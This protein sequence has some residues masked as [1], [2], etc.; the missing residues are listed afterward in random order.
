[1][2]KSPLNWILVTQV[3]MYIVNLWKLV[4]VV[5]PGHATMCEQASGPCMHA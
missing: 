1:M 3:H 4:V 2:S 5:E